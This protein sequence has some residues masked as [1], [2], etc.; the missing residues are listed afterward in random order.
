MQ[1]GGGPAA[2]LR[3]GRER[4]LRDTGQDCVVGTS[5]ARG[6]GKGRE[7]GVTGREGGALARI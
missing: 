5:V 2:P 3:R 6:A 7:C 4:D 1:G